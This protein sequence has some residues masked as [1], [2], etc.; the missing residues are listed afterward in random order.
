[1]KANFPF[2]NEDASI[3][4]LQLKIEVEALRN[5]LAFVAQQEK[6]LPDTESVTHALRTARQF[7]LEEFEKTSP[8]L[9][10][11]IDH[12]EIDDVL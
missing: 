6:P 12:R 10:S 9:A 2:S 8:E 3:L 1:M 7:A 4:I 11:I 5:T